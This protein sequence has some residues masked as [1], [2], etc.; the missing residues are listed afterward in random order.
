MKTRISVIVCSL[1]L[2]GAAYGWADGSIQ[3]NAVV[4]QTTYPFSGDGANVFQTEST[5]MSLRIN[6]GTLVT[7]MLNVTVLFPYKNGEKNNLSNSFAGIS[8]EDKPFILDTLIGL[9]YVIDLAD[10]DIFTGTGFHFGLFSQGSDSL[11][12]YGLGLDFQVLVHWG[13]VFTLSGGMYGSMDFA[14]DSTLGRGKIDGLIWGLGFS[15]GLAVS[16]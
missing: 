1:M 6:H 16:Y 9:G 12:S 7:G 15:F 8:G 4:Q 3:L 13:E 5:G 2:L 14:S 11:L 10:I